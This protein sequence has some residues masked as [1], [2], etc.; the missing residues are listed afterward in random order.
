MRRKEGRKWINLISLYLNY[1]F[2]KSTIIIFLVSILFMI[3]ALIIIINPNFDMDLYK[4]NP[5][6][7]HEKYFMQSLFVLSIFNG[8]L[9]TTIS[10]IY[11]LQSNSF[12]ALFLSFRS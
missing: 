5:A 12:D 11:M 2:Q 6:S 8:I 10:I 4:I 9:V 1:V 3:L 7:F